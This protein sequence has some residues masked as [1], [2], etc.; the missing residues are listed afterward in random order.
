MVARKKVGVTNHEP[1]IEEHVDRDRH[2]S[3][4]V[5]LYFSVPELY[6]GRLRRW[7]KK[8]KHICYVL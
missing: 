6:E 4:A 7:G 1:T 2:T 3:R 8:T 5:L